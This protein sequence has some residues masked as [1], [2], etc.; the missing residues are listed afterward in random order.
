MIRETER[1]VHVY[2]LMCWSDTQI[3][4][5]TN[6]LRATMERIYTCTWCTYSCDLVCVETFG[7][8]LLVL[9]TIYGH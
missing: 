8:E 1:E 4:A 6:W 2:G 9:T 3:D 5:I 7:A